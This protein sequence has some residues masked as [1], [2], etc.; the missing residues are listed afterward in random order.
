V[1]TDASGARLIE[2]AGRF[3]F[4]AG[5]HGVDRWDL[6]AGGVL[7]I[8]A[9]QGLPGDRV[10]ALA[11][12][13]DRGWL[14]VATDGGIGYYD[15]ASEV[16]SALPP[17][18]PTLSL[19]LGNGSIRLASAAD[20]GL[21][22]G[23]QKG[24]LY[25]SDAAWV[26]TPIVDPVMSVYR[27]RDGWLWIATTKGMIGRK[28]SGETLQYG[29]VHGCAV[30]KPRILVTAPGGGLFAIGEDAAGKQRLALW[31]SGAWTSYRVN[32]EVRWEMAVATTD[33]V[34][35]MGGGRLYRL[36]ARVE[37]QVRPLTRDGSRVIPLAAGGS[38]PFVV[39]A[40]PAE[41]PP[42]PLAIAGAGDDL[43]VSTTD[44]GLARYGKRGGRPVQ[45][46]RRRQMLDSASSLSVACRA[47]DD[48]WLAVG[49]KRGW[50]W[51][52]DR[53]EPGGPDLVV[54]AVVRDAAGE[55][56]AL[57]RGSEQDTLNLSKIVGDEWVQ[58]QG[59]TIKPPGEAPSVSF[60][61]FAPTG[62]LWVGLLYQDGPESTP[63]GVAVI[64]VANSKVEYHRATGP[65]ERRPDKDKSRRKDKN[66]KPKVM[67]VPVGTVD[68]AFVDEREVWFATSEGAARMV[69]GKIQMWSE[70]DNMPS[71]LLHGIAATA[72]GVVFVGSSAGIGV[73]DGDTWSHPRALA[74]SIND[75]GVTDDGK[76]WMA[77]DR[78]LAVYDGR[79]V[80]R[81]DTRRGLVD[82]ELAD[83]AIDHLGRVWAR[84]K[85]SIVMLTP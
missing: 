37:G 85:G 1:F 15:V 43:I 30:E 66:K 7:P 63:W 81:L 79:K 48:C 6:A 51:L 23:H 21:W 53:F 50:H 56:Y 72:G 3:V 67:P 31:R 45:W 42:Q 5:A 46:L 68:A 20:G 57:H 65:E 69:D 2:P 38:S 40:L 39:D 75:L 80:R 62:A 54:L 11:A 47:A 64:D 10:A 24:L 26:S 27:D 76:L 52:G 13:R 60:A 34:I 9:D 16:F 12:D 77:T 84:S 49:A 29:P 17:P 82:N 70:R 41:L 19:D 8:G 55:I 32:P 61:R 14:W 4:A 59:V 78:G 33:A 22:V 73:F 36:A 58:V 74:F 28:P 83:L 18:P 44:Q 35:A 25:A 71:E